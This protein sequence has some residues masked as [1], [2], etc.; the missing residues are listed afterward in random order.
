MPKYSHFVNHK[1]NLSFRGSEEIL[2]SNHYYDDDLLT[3]GEEAVTLSASK[4]K[5]AVKSGTKATTKPE[6]KK[7]E[8]IGALYSSDP[9]LSYQTRQDD[10]NSS[11]ASSHSI[12]CEI[13]RNYTFHSCS[14]PHEKSI[15]RS[16]PPTNEFISRKRSNTR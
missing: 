7:D 16:H 15:E 4:L 10:K 3:L 14:S 8:I 5:P 12:T 13:A 1:G 6:K 2:N 9:P 11:R